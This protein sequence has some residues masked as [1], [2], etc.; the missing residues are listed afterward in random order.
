MLV[1]LA[2]DKARLDELRQAYAT[3]WHGSRS[4]LSRRP[5]TSTTS[6]ASRPRRSRRTSTRS[7]PSG[8][9]RPSRGCSSRPSR[10]TTQRSRGTRRGSAGPTRSP[11][12]CRKKLR[13]EEAL[14]TEYSGVRLRMDLDRVPLWRRRPRRT[15]SSS[16]ATTAST[17]TCPGCVTRR[18]CL[19]PCGPASA[20]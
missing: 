18:C 2:P 19:T 7:S 20:F 15:R 4:R 16:G 9:A 17:S 14:I 6:S 13:S 5:S 12:G 3:T 10:P 1:F 8:S 11:C